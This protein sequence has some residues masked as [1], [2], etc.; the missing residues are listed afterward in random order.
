M[1]RLSLTNIIFSNEKTIRW[2][3]QEKTFLEKIVLGYQFPKPV[4]SGNYRYDKL[5]DFIEKEKN[6]GNFNKITL[7]IKDHEFPIERYLLQFLL[8]KNKIENEFFYPKEFNKNDYSE[9]NNYETFLIV[10]S[11]ENFPI[12]SE[13]KFSRLEKYINENKDN[14]SI[15]D[16]NM[17]KF[18]FLLSSKQLTKYNFELNK[19]YNFFEKFQACLIAK[20]N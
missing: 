18:L 2:S 8:N 14:M 3:N 15:A 6:K 5:I 4:N 12:F 17:N 1:Q 10:L 9:L 13:K 19:C 7:V 20:N 11:E 16:Y